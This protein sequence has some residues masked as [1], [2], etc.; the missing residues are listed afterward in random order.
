MQL[1]PELRSGGEDLGH[2]ERGPDAAAGEPQLLTTRTGKWWVPDVQSLRL[3][4]CFSAHAGDNVHFGVDICKDRLDNFYWKNME[5][6]VRDFCLQCVHCSTVRHLYR[7]ERSA[8][9]HSLPPP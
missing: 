7:A 9:S 8:S 5:E 1:E 3:R 4:M 2:Y 6:E